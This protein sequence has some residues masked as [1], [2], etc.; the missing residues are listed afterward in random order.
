VL[1]FVTVKEQ[2]IS[3]DQTAESQGNICARK[4][5]TNLVNETNM[6]HNILSIILQ[7]YL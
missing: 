2:T 4:T 1:K 6:V 7:F 3:S 5:E